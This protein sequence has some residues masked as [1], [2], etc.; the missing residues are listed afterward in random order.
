MRAKDKSFNVDFKTE[1]DPDLPK[2][3]VVQQDIGRVILN[4]I[5]NAFQALAASGASTPN[6]LPPCPL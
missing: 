3:N 4:L 1:L 6:P 2:V 5:N